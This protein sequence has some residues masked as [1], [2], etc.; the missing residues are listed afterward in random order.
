MRYALEQALEYMPPAEP[1]WYACY[2]KARHEKRVEA[3]LQ[4]RSLE[5]FLPLV[6]RMRQWKD[7]RRL[8]DFPMFPSYVF[9]RALPEELYRVTSVPGVC[10]VVRNQGEPVTIAAEELENVRRFADALRRRHGGGPEPEP[11]PYLAEGQAV[12]V[13]AGPLQGVRGVVVERRNRRRVLVGLR[14]IGQGLEVDVDVAFLRPV[15]NS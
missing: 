1:R 14:A 4:E 2:T 12:E 8:V 6:A 13:T 3:A 11:V 9:V 15:E 7:R 10:F 5:T